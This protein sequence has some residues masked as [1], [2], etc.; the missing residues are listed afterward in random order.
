MMPKRPPFVPVAARVVACL[1]TLL[2]SAA[3]AQTPAANP[4]TRPLRVM[5]LADMEGA[6]GIDDYRMTTVDHP[7]RYA[8]GR[9]QITADVNAAIAGLKAAGVTDIVVI[10]G[11]GSGNSRE[12]DVI[13]ADLL[14]PARIGYKETSFDI[15]MDAYDHSVDAIVAVGMHAGAGNR[16]GFLSHTYQF[17]DV[18]YRV[19]GVPFNESMILAAGAARLR[20]PVIAIAGD[21]QLETEI[22]RAMPWVKYA[23]I[24]RAV[25]RS[26]AELLP[27]ADANR[28]I[29]QAVREAVQQLGTMKLPEWP[30]PYRITVTFQDEAQARNAQLLAGA[31]PGF[32]ATQAQ[33]RGGDF[34]E[35]YRRSILLM[36]LGGHIGA[37]SSLNATLNAQSDAARLNTA[38]TDWSY[39]RFLDPQSPL[40]AGATRPRF[41]GAR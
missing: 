16:K 35:A 21:D 14:A 20:I 2:G 10:D 28:R 11:H 8:E 36:R 18:D 25:D 30:A 4:T 6:A 13:E 1:A 9:R 23:T 32:Y 27:R 38:E 22:R 19:N 15:Y 5:I 39:A 34:E 12:P 3:S 33:V 29:E 26:K 24:K 40:P 37:L 7:E 17:E 41:W 31:E